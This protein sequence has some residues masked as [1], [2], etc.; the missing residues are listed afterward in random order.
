MDTFD[1]ERLAALGRRR[2]KLNS[3]LADNRNEIIPEVLAAVRARV[4]QARIVELSGYTR[5]QIRRLCR[6]A[7]IEAD[8]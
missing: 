2:R 6:A 8:S 3:D 1:T 7:G 5:E 4:P